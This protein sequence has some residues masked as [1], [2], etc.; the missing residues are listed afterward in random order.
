M[1][2]MEATAEGEDV[3]PV[4]GATRR[5]QDELAHRSWDGMY[6]TRPAEAISRMTESCSANPLLRASWNGSSDWRSSPQGGMEQSAILAAVRGLRSRTISSTFSRETFRRKLPR[7]VPGEPEHRLVEARLLGHRCHH[8]VPAEQHDH[9]V[10][11]AGD[12]LRQQATV[13]QVAPA[14]NL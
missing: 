4:E 9:E 8:V 3:E 6:P 12:H 1:L 14:A 7:Q 10:G 5:R 13:C 11:M 2:P